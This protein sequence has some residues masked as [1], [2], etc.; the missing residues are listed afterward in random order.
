[1]K[2]TRTWKTT[3]RNLPSFDRR[4]PKFITYQTTGMFIHYSVNSKISRLIYFFIDLRED[5]SNFET[6]DER[7]YLVFLSIIYSVFVLISKESKGKARSCRTLCFRFTLGLLLSP[8]IVTEIDVAKNRCFLVN[9]NC[10]W[11]L[12]SYRFH[13]KWLGVIMLPT[14]SKILLIQ[15]R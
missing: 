7:Y 2:W 11:F 1:M 5:S 10:T 3:D 14:N 4:V 6:I 15:K 9:I 8:T 12:F 13:S